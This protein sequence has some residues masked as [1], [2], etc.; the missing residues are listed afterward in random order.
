MFNRIEIEKLVNDGKS[1]SE[2]AR[3]LGKNVGSI[4]NFCKK[5]NIISK[6]INKI[7]CKELPI[8][9]IYDLYVS[10]KSLDFLRQKFDVPIIRIKK[11]LIKF[12][13]D[14]KF[15]TMDEVKRPSVLN[16]REKLLELSSKMSFTK[17]AKQ[18]GVKTSTVCAAG[19]RLGVV[20]N[21][22]FRSDDV[23][24]EQLFDLYINKELRV[25]E[26]VNNLGQSYG[27]I[28]RKLRKFKFPIRLPGGLPSDSKYELFNNKDNLFDLYINKNHSM[29]DIADIVGS[30]VSMVAYNLR[31]YGIKIRTKSEYLSMLMR[32]GDKSIINNISVDSKLEMKFLRSINSNNIL[33]NVE[34]ESCGSIAYIDFCVNGDFIEV[35]PKEQSII[36]GASR[37]RLIKQ[38]L[39]AKGN[40]I[41][42]K[43]WNGDYYDLKIIDIDIYYLS[44]WKLWFKTFNECA[45]WLINFGFHGTEYS[46]SELYS[47]LNKSL[48]VKDGF[49]LNANFPNDDTIKFIRHFSKHFWYSTHRDYRSI[50]D[51]WNIG[52]HSVL[53]EAIRELWCKKSEVNIFGLVKYIGKMFK[54]FTPVSIF[55]PW[56]ARFI[57]NKYLP[58]GGVIVDPCMGWGGRLLGCLDS[59][60][61][62]KGIDLNPSSVDANARIYKFARS[63]FNA[64]DF[65]NADSSICDIPS[66]DLLFTSPPYDD[67]E[68]YSGIDSNKTLTEPI[69]VNIFSK[70]NGIIILNL[71]RRM[72]DLCNG[73]ALRFNYKLVEEL[74][75][76]TASFMGRVKTFEPILVYKTKF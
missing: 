24:R 22:D 54:D 66:G 45:D 52:N 70:F 67:C 53:K 16:N 14:I 29:G 44:N 7:V 42:V 57:Y 15:R 39:V 61:K 34:F 72:V 17:I 58:N 1:F 32:H 4:S 46:I 48:K 38:V 41:D 73:V 75:M 65:L 74:E 6:H 76:K 5:N 13:S 28:L 30:S 21:W 35:K 27:C 19:K 33:R 23:S 47:F 26:I 63:R 36:P 50:A 3:I 37:R 9:E 18:L 60:F 59:K 10:G 68:L 31:K 2:I 71:P 55:K 62:Y 43:I 11:H 8:M 20:S 51:A 25:S 56:V 64:C 49:E 12:K 40:G 69:L